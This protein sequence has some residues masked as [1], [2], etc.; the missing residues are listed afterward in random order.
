[1]NRLTCFTII[2][3]LGF[4][5]AVSC[6]N[7]AIVQNVSDTQVKTHSGINRNAQ[8]V[9][10]SIDIQNKTLIIPFP[11]SGAPWYE[12]YARPDYWVK[13]YY[14]GFGIYVQFS[15]ATTVA[16]IAGLDL[17][18]IFD[19]EP[20]SRA[21]LAAA[22]VISGFIYFTYCNGQGVTIFFAYHIFGGTTMFCNEDMFPVGNPN[23]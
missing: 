19:Q 23:N 12:Y 22:A 5:L 11:P 7:P 3:T 13:V 15:H 4:L 9:Q 14:W 6:D 10:N 1:M 2:T 16:V 18:A 21:V 20:I 8:A 17:A